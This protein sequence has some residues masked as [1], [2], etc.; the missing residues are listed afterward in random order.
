MKKTKSV[1]LLA[2]FFMTF[3]M[4]A[5]AQFNLKTLLTQAA[6]K[7]ETPQGTKTMYVSVKNGSNRN[8]GSQ[9]SPIKDLQKAIDLAPEGAVILV[10]EGNY[11]GYLDQGWVKVTKYVSIIGGYSEDF[12][13]RDP[14]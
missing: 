10:S 13:E 4:S 9:S 6:P 5:S 8:D 3:S 1:Y 7:N 11:L 14:I 12:S 2:L